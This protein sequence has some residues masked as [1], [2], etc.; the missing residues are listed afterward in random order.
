MFVHKLNTFDYNVP[1][2]FKLKCNKMCKNVPIGQQGDC[3]CSNV[4]QSWAETFPAFTHLNVLRTENPLTKGWQH[5]SEATL[6]TFGH[7]LVKQKTCSELSVVPSYLWLLSSR[8]RIKKSKAMLR[9]HLFYRSCKTLSRHPVISNGSSTGFMW[10]DFD[11]GGAA[12]LP[13]VSRHQELP[14]CQT[15][16]VPATSKVNVPKLGLSATL[17]A[18]LW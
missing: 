5:H 15:K 12:W 8:Y 7:L 11:S 6:L 13:S 18:P 10:Q 1:W 4:F 16:P 3:V 9:S 14:P 17:A 2:I